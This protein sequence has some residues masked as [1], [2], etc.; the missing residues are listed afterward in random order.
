[1]I[2]DPLSLAD[3]RRRVSD[4]YHD[5]RS[6]AEPR[7]AWAQWRHTRDALFREHAQSPI[8]AEARVQFTGLSYFD[9]DPAAR[10]VVALE[11]L[12]PP[13][14][15]RML[16]EGDG[17]LDLQPFARTKGL[18]AAYG[19][20]LTLFWIA[21]YGGGVFLPFCD[22]TSGGESYAGGRY[23]L[24]GIKGADLGMEHGRVVLDFNFAYHP[25]C[26]YSPRW[27]CPLSPAENRLPG[28]VRAGERLV[29][30]TAAFVPSDRATA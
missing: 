14:L 20:E 29:R 1:M 30:A 23:L 17:Q 9:Y 12:A 5:V 21:G 18:A 24:D 16:L 3:W 8:A 11:P 25:S 6:A 28:A 13:A 10:H 4:L 19:G 27:E 15:E 26:V 22:G 2:N 7:A